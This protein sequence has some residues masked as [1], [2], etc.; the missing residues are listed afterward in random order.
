[1]CKSSGDVLLLYVED[2]DHGKVDFA[3]ARAITRPRLPVAVQ[4]HD[5]MADQ[6]PT[7]RKVGGTLASGLTG[8]GGALQN[9]SPGWSVEFVE[10]A[11][12]PAMSLHL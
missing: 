3:W 5:T 11:A 10:G 7:T 2:S 8:G 4:N 1:M 9:M 12:G 6:H